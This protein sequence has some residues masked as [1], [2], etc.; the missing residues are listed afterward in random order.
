M[1][2]RA[3]AE[4]SC[5]PKSALCWQNVERGATGPR[6]MALQYLLRARGYNLAPDGKFAFATESVLRRFQRKNRL[7]VDGK[8]G[9]QSWE[10]LTPNLQA[11]ARGNAVRGLQTMLVQAGYKV[12]RDGVFGASTQKALVSFQRPIGL[13]GSDGRATDPVWCYLTGGRFDGE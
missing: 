2:T 10:A 3:R 4:E 7:K 8:A 9:W 13:I 1:G 11:G 6:V 12:T 5:G